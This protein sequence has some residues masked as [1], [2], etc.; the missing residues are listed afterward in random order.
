[1]RRDRMYITNEVAGKLKLSLAI[2][3]EVTPNY[4]EAR[5]E[6]FSKLRLERSK[7]TT[8]RLDERLGRSS[9][10]ANFGWVASN[11]WKK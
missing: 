7:A 11:P 8:D 5:L 2:G 3:S 4:F 10:L 9:N 1:M 6:R